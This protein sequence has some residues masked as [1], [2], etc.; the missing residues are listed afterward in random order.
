M[1]NLV[2]IAIKQAH[3]E[4]AKIAKFILMRTELMCS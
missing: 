1:E 3:H 4:D 2:L